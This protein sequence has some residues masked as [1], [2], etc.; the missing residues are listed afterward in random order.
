MLFSALSRMHLH[1]NRAL[2]RCALVMRAAMALTAFCAVTAAGA[3]ERNSPS[4]GLENGLRT[5]FAAAP[6]DDAAARNGDRKPPEAVAVNVSPAQAARSARDQYGGKVLGVT[7]ASEA[8]A[9][10]YRVKLL[11]GGSVRVVHVAA[12]R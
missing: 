11:D 10:Y 6:G 3:A 12:H 9:P 1:S 7:L 4:A 5:P 8:R 2:L